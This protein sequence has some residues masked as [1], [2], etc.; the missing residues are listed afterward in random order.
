METEQQRRQNGLL[1]RLYYEHIPALGLRNYWHPVCRGREI[2]QK[3]KAFT[4]MGDP[5]AIM[6]RNGKLFA[7]ANECPHR[8]AQLA[9]G[10]D[11]FPGKCTV[12]CRYHGWT[13]DLAD[14]RLV[15]ALTDG[16][17]SPIVEK[18]ICVRTYPV[19]ERRGIVW[20]WLANEAPVPVEQDIP[21]AMLA[22]DSVHVVTRH[23]RGNW[24]WHVENPGLGHATMLHRDS[25]YMRFV[26]MFG[27]GKGFSA[28]LVTEGIDG[29]WLQ[30][31]MTGYGRSAEFPGLGEWPVHRFG[32]VIPL[33]EMPAVQ[34]VRTIVSAKLPGIIRITN[35][36]IRGVM[37]YEWFTQTDADHYIYFQTCC[38]FAENLPQRLSF[39]LRF[40][41]WGR[42][43]GMVRFNKQDLAMIE[44][45][46]DYA[47]RHNFNDPAP[48][49]RPDQFQIAWRRYL[50][51]RCRGL[52]LPEMA[53]VELPVASGESRQAATADAPIPSG[54]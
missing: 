39:W 51:K 35:F 34:G 5:V 7:V 11:E 16:P 20:I 53:D 8:G 3:P 29:E 27:F 30:E 2:G 48:L 49:Y 1:N 52:N 17:D 25:L 44:H 6:R 12:T 45:S 31:L 38:S 19:E 40:F 28:P 32:E 23:V 46:H 21:A 54:A 43:V 9:F 24:R 33:A 42:Y 26:D 13:F 18:N 50:L 36:P 4:L 14:G 47:K 41:L 15:A 37:Y 22:A 10:T